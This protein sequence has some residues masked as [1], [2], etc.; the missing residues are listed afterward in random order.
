MEAVVWSDYLCPWCYVGQDRTALLR[1]LGVSV[2]VLPFELHPR[3]PEEGIPNTRRYSAVAAE[4]EAVGLPFRPPTRVPNT[5]RVLAAAEWVRRRE[6][7]SFD[8]L[9]AALFRASFV[10]G[11]DLGDPAVLASLLRVDVD[12]EEGS[13]WV[14]ESMAQ[15]RDV[16]VFAT[17]AWLFDSGVVIAGVQPRAFFERIVARSGGVPSR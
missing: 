3:V 7:E 10:D 13:A 8:M 1:S 4:C 9:H 6:P 5:R 14:D 15:A 12:F 17:P 11:L 16:D 2:T